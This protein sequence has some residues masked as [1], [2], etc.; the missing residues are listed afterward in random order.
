MKNVFDLQKIA[1]TAEI[2]T[3]RKALIM[4]G[5]PKDP[6][7]YIIHHMSIKLSQAQSWVTDKLKTLTNTSKGLNLPHDSEVYDYLADKLED[8]ND[9]IFFIKAIAEISEELPYYEEY[10][11]EKSHDDE[12]FNEEDSPFPDFY[13]WK[14]GKWD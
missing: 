4:G 6:T 8:K 9:L 5:D 11:R 2:G 13:N 3:G 10:Y 1:N 12:H 14:S 7:I